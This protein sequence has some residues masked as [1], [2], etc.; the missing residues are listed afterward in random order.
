MSRR[1]AGSIGCLGTLVLA[2]VVLWVGLPAARVYLRAWQYEDVLRGELQFATVESD[3][4]MLRKM[5]AAVD[6][7]DGLPDEAY[8]I[9]IERR[10]TAIRILGGYEDT[11]ALPFGRGKAVRHDFRLERAP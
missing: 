3:S 2:A 9:R 5:R 6:S 1:G 8:N 7:I 4:V 10:N 11:I